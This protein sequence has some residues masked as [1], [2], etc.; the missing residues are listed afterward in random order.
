MVDINWTVLIQIA[1]FLF[2]LFV[3]NTILYKPLRSIIRQRKSKMEGLEQSITSAGRNTEEKG[4]AFTEGLKEA[5]ADGQKR[6]EAML[7]SAVDEEKAI[8]AGINAKAQEDLAAVKAKIAKDTEAVR[9]ALEKEIDVFANAIT[10]KILGR[11]A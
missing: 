8:V 2:L 7:Q 3:L 9:N 4:Q 5:R 6:K 10:E 11:A 1:N